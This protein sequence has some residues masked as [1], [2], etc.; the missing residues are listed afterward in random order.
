MR[1]IKRLFLTIIVLTFVLI[2]ISANMNETNAS[3]LIV[4]KDHNGKD[5]TYRNS[6]EKVYQLAEY[7][8]PTNQLRAVWVSAFVSDIP[9]YKNE[10]QNIANEAKAHK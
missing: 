6:S 4:M 5:I 9:S 7:N 1:Q 10:A 3:G 8:Y 2:G